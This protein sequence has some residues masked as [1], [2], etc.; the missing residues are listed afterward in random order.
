MKIVI[1]DALG[2]FKVVRANVEIAGVVVCRIAPHAPDQD[3]EAEFSSVME[4]VL[5]IKRNPLILPPKPTH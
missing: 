1:N 4:A 5:Y 2:T 3:V